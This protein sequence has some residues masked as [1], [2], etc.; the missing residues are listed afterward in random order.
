MANLGNVGHNFPISG[1]THSWQFFT[2]D[3]RPTSVTMHGVS[4][5]PSAF[6]VLTR[7]AVFNYRTRCDGSGNWFFYDMDDSG[8]QI[9]SISTYTQEG[10][11][12]EVWRATV[13]GN[14]VVVTKTFS[15]NRAVAAAFA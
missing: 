5:I 9:Y 1:E 11:T 13:T 2:F 10:A 12:G 4:D 8:G 3:K 6:A 15:S 7:N 14:V